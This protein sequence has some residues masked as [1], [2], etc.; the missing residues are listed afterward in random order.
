MNMTPRS[1]HNP[2]NPP[3]LWDM[4]PQSFVSAE[5]AIRTWFEYSGRAQERATKF[6]NHRWAKDAAAL[7]QLGQCRTP[8]EAVNAQV[9]Y[10]TGACADYISEGQ[11][12]VGI[13]SDIAREAMPRMFVDQTNANPK[14]VPRRVGSH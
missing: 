11:K 10:L 7:A 14:R 9:T 8:V 1:K 12:L 4:D 2:F 6:L 5:T 3:S 13:L